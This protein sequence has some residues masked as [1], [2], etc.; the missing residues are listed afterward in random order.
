MTKTLGAQE[1]WNF[2]SW[3]KKGSAATLEKEETR[4][5]SKAVAK[6]G[7]NDVGKACLFPACWRASKLF[8]AFP[9]QLP[10]NMDILIFAGPHIMFELH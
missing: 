7:V 4:T 10:Q 1:S 2:V 3:W 8:V 9:K 6:N 5:K